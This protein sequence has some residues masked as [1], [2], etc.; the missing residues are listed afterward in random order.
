MIFLGDARERENPANTF[1]KKTI[2]SSY[3]AI[4]QNYD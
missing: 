3:T 1:V 2:K 4:N